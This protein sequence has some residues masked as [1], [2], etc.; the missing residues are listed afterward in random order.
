V[1][2]PVSLA[3]VAQVCIAYAP[4]GGTTVV[5]LCQRPKLQMEETFW[6]TLPEER[7]HGTRLVFR[8]GR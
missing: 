5:V 2:Q 4:E 3:S 7:R 6:R 1:P 8:Q